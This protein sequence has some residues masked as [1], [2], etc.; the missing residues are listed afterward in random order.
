MNT[1]DNLR[2]SNQ[3][4]NEFFEWRCLPAGDGIERRNV[5]NV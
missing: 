1:L 3:M 5:H 2:K 4:T